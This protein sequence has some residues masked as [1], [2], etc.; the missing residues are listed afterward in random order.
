MD[1]NKVILTGRVG[2]DPEIKTLN[3]GNFVCNLSV[4]TEM[5]WKKNG[6]IQK[7]SEWHKVV[8]FDENI[9]NYCRDFIKAGDS[10]YIEARLTYRVIEASESTNGKKIKIA[11]LQV[12]KFGGMIAINFKKRSDEHNVEAQDEEFSNFL[13]EAAPKGGKKI[14][15]I[16]EDEI[17]FDI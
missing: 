10:V 9:I 3:N 16:N 6:E 8:T 5:T 2:Q 13:D 12:P 11:E 14:K 7:K 15:K 1:I 17:P 4:V